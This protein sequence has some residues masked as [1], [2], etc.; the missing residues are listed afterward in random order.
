V[1]GII[2]DGNRIDKIEGS[3]ATAAIVLK[4]TPF[5]AESG[6]QVG[7]TGT[8]TSAA[9]AARV[10][11]TQSPVAGVVVHSVVLDF[12]QFAIDQDVSAQV[13][14]DKRNRIAANHTGTHLLHATLRDTLG[15]HV[16]QA[17]SLVATDRLRFDYTHY[18]ALTGREI[19]EVEAR[20]N[21][22]VLENH[23][24]STR[25][26]GLNEAI[27]SGATA[28]FGEKYQQNVRVVS[29]P[30]VSMELC[31]G[32]HTRMTGDIGLFKIVSES[33]V[34]SG[35]RRVEALTG[36]GSYER[37]GEDEQLIESLS[38]QLR[39]PRGELSK[40]I[41]RTMDRQKHLEE[42][43]KTLKRQGASSQLEDLVESRRM[44][45]DVAVISQKVEGMDVPLMRELAEKAMANAGRGI[46]VLG[47]EADGKAM[48]VTT[49]SP[50]L[51][52]QLHAGKVVK[53]VSEMV[54]GNGGGRPDFAQAG[55]KEPEKLDQALQAVYNI[56]ADLMG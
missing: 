51:R 3:G 17:G 50:D 6:G 54:G 7:D 16:K 37:F 23:S 22:I 4:Q 18:A 2:S 48:L 1:I 47:T 44:V 11:D 40:A 5:Y 39:A 21:R 45:G 10:V 26:M 30:N 13:D 33:S 35:I 38:N 46:V 42:E 49:V 25:E 27:E 41:E 31:G 36:L 43:L 15:V 29:I 55:G 20:I 32:T 8:L 24:V 12:G 52:K 28:F 9:G 34:A 14:R 53:R 19:E 56:V